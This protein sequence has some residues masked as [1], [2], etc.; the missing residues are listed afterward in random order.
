MLSDWR[1][2]TPSASTVLYY[3]IVLFCCNNP[4]FIKSSLISPMYVC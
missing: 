4:V 1:S 2:E 3:G